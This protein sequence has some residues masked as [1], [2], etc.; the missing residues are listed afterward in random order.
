MLS[1]SPAALL[2]D[3]LLDCVYI[4]GEVAKQVTVAC[5]NMAALLVCNETP[6]GCHTPTMQSVQQMRQ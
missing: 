3:G 1:I 2:D 6:L 5:L 4:V